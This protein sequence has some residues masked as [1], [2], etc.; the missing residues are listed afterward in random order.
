MTIEQFTY[1]YDYLIN[2]FPSDDNFVIESDIDGYHIH[3][4]EGIVLLSYDPTNS[5]YIYANRP[6]KHFNKER[7]QKWAN[8][9][10]A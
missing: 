9:Y 7:W 6:Y 5:T 1:R 8:N 10:Y 2:E 3:N 4:N